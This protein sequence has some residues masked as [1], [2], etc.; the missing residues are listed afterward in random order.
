MTFESSLLLFLAATL[1]VGGCAACGYFVL[2]MEDSPV[3][4]S[5][6]DYAARLERHSS[7]LLMSYRGAQLARAQ[8]VAC[9]AFVALFA[10]AGSPVFALLG[11]VAAAAP[12]F[13]LW[14]RHVARVAQL[15]RQLDTWLL[16]LANAL[17]T[18]SSVGEAIASTVALVPKPF[19]EE[20]D[21]LVKEIR[22]GAPLDRALHALSR[23]INSTLISGALA[24]I[25][26]A[27]QTGGD[28]PRTL[29]SASAALREAARL[30]GVLRTRT[31]EGR[32]QVLV[33]ASVPFV[34]CVIIAWLDRAWFDP[35][36]NNQIG[37][38]ILA[39]CSVV[40]TFAALW[41]HHIV[42]ADL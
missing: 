31:A 8:V 16:M 39:A 17:K 27:R 41:A 36:L 13:L 6:R 23:R 24:T 21:L 34:L 32:G 10:V 3:E 35:M 20:V 12:P 11:L 18:T 14:K 1:A 40:W 7:F 26:V 30:E 4:R 42:K 29:E 5:F 25:V 38:A 22:L 28:L 15:E 2:S 19:S 37:Q 33:L 9:I